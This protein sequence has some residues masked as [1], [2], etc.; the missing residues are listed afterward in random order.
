MKMKEHYG[1]SIPI[2]SARLITQYHAHQMFEQEEQTAKNPSVPAQALILLETDGS[3][4]PIVKTVP[5]PEDIDVYDARKHKTHFWREARLS[6]ARPIGSVTPVF[7][8]TFGK[9]EKVG[10]QLYACA[11]QAGLDDDSKIHGLGDGAPWIVNQIEEQFGTQA[12]YLVDFYHVCEY[13]SEAA[14]TMGDK[15]K[16]WVDQQKERLKTGGLDEVLLELKT[17]L[18]ST[19]TKDIEAPKRRCYRYLENRR[20]QLDYAGAIKKGLPIGSGE[21][22]S[23]HRYV[24]QKR[25]K[26]SGAWWEENNAANMLALRTNRANRNWKSYWESR[27]SA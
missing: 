27:K 10:Q 7:S 12:T 1:I 20:D 8:A 26:I 11:K 14:Q 9:P 2:S 18:E 13:L 24:I 23:A 4:V 25:L 16:M 15:K 19:E 22:E 5:K 21:I 17:F 6:F 3:M